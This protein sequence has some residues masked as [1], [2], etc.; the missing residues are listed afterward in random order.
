MTQACPRPQKVPRVLLCFVVN[1]SNKHT[2]DLW[3]IT[4]ITLANRSRAMLGRHMDVLVITNESYANSIHQFATS[5][6]CDGL[7]SF[8]IACDHVRNK[9]F[10]SDSI[11]TM[12]FNRLNYDTC[13]Y[14]HNLKQ[15]VGVADYILGMPRVKK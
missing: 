14:Q 7:W 10:F 8:W 1:H 3:K 15:S 6:G 13:T 2:V 11:V 4:M 5:C 9:L 12:N